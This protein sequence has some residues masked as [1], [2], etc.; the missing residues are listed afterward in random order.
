MKGKKSRTGLCA[1]ILR[2]LPMFVVRH[3]LSD[4]WQAISQ[5]FSSWIP[6]FPAI[7]CSVR[8]CSLLPTPLK[9]S[10]F[11]SVVSAD[12]FI[13]AAFE[14]SYRSICIRDFRLLLVVVDPITR[15]HFGCWSVSWNGTLAVAW[16]LCR[17]GCKRRGRYMRVKN[18]RDIWYVGRVAWKRNAGCSGRCLTARIHADNFAS[19]GSEHRDN[20]ADGELLK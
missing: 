7:C 20:G 8:W 15:H 16:I 6:P 17:R 4:L 14:F 1:E 18:E 13:E 3:T 19:A 2:T 12:G 9:T 10:G 5:W 11:I